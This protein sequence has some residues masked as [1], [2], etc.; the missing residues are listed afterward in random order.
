M[1]DLL[2]AWPPGAGGTPG[3]QGDPCPPCECPCAGSCW[4][5]LSSGVL[6]LPEPG[7]ASPA[8]K[9]QWEIKAG[10]RSRMGRKVWSD[11]TC[12]GTGGLIAPVVMV[13]T[14]SS[15]PW[16]PSQPTVLPL[17]SPEPPFVLITRK[18]MTKGAGG[19]GKCPAK[20]KHPWWR[21]QELDRRI[22]RSPWFFPYKDTPSLGCPHGT[23]TFPL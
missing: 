11:S 20:P 10:A 15:C 14:G 21:G 6:L 23:G 1:R 13:P 7:E 4:H 22:L 5:H 8:R 16:A 19:S 9:L 2:T 18:D 3:R 17:H 12:P